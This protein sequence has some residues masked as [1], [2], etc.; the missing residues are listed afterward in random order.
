MTTATDRDGVT[1]SRDAARGSSDEKEGDENEGDKNT[2]DSKMQEQQLTGV[3]GD[4]VKAVRASAHL[5]TKLKSTR[6]HI[7][8]TQTGTF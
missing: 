7:S 8:T 3:S 4:P 5:N 2:E 1:V 6:E